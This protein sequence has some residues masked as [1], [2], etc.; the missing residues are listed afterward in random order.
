MGITTKTFGEWLSADAKEF[1]EDI[2]RHKA[3]Y[4]SN[5][6][7]AYI[8]SV[9]TLVLRLKNELFGETIVF[10]VESYGTTKNNMLAVDAFV[11]EPTP[12]GGYRRCSNPLEPEKKWKMSSVISPKQFQEPL[13]KGALFEASYEIQLH[14]KHLDE[15]LKIKLSTYRNVQE[16][17]LDHLNRLGNTLLAHATEEIFG[18]DVEKTISTKF[19]DRQDILDQEYISKYTKL[20]SQFKQLQEKE[21]T[22]NQRLKELS[23]KQ[24]Q[25]MQLLDKIDRHMQL[26]N[27]N[28]EE[29]EQ[30]LYPW[31]SEKAVEMLQSLLYHNSE[32][33]L[34]YDE[35]TIEMFLRALQTNTLVILSGP[36][37]TG[38]SS[39]VT[40]TANAIKGAKAKI[41]PIQSGWTD[42]QDLI[43]YF[44]PIDKSFVATPFM[45]ALAD[46]AREEDH[47][48]LICLD[49]MNLAHVEHYF[50]EFLS[51]REQKKQYIQLYNKRFYLQAKEIIEHGDD[52]LNREQLFAAQELIE[53]FP[54]RF[55]IPQNVR[56]VGT[57]NMDHTVKSLSPKVIDRS[58]V[59]EVDHIDAKEKVEIEKKL[60]ENKKSGYIDVSLEQFDSFYHIKHAFEKEAQALVDISHQLE[61]ITNASLNSRGK[62]QIGLYLDHVPN[63]KLTKSLLEKYYDQLIMTKILPRIEVSQ[64]DDQSMSIVSNFHQSLLNYP[65]SAKKLGK[66]LEN[67]RIVRFW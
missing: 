44:N 65:R 36:S 4:E 27:D 11:M 62:K 16:S 47:L 66:M 50:S 41:I 14:Q 21:E 63:Q 32:D 26:E 23:E 58:F 29:L 34:V 54:Y 17:F 28:E 2:K 12:E 5:E 22:Y 46:A 59:I 45:E 48:H 3:L 1:I 51:I 25:W 35:V 7:N 55:E 56:F 53:R 20:E 60:N 8:A 64:R 18:N 38:K 13:V 24:I 37:G 19:F 43:G 39:L 57:I 40:G 42:T 10:E 9:G 15:L 30:Q 6:D 49:E 67:K 61:S 33:D 31:E 52:G